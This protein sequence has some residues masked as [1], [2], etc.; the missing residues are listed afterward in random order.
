[1]RF[2]SIIGNYY[3][4][5]EELMTGQQHENKTAR[6]FPYRL[7]A[8]A[9][10]VVVA[11]VCGPMA[12]LAATTTLA[13]SGG[14]DTRR[15]QAACNAGRVVLADGVF[16]VTAV[17]CRNIVS[18]NA[19]AFFYYQGQQPTTKLKGTSSSVRGVLVCPSPGPCLYRGFEVDPPP[20][21]GGIVLDGIHGAQLLEMSVIDDGGGNSGDCVDMNPTTQEDNQNIFVRGGT[22]E[23]CG[24]WCFDFG[25]NSSGLGLSDSAWSGVDVAD[26]QAGGI[27]VSFGYNNHFTDNRIQDQYGKVGIRLDSGGVDVVT[28][29]T[30]D[31][32][33]SD[34]VLGNVYL[35]ATGNMS[36]RL[37]GGAM[38]DI[39]GQVSINA[40][41]NRSCNPTYLM[42]SNG[43]F[44][45]G[46]FYDP[47]PSYADQRTQNLLSGAIR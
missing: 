34:I 13:P 46:A 21:V 40:S 31:Q 4:R 3:S 2:D 33:Y 8:I 47:L 27:Y 18:E 22:Y 16:N 41:A 11:F 6:V 17:T 7:A 25:P 19:D 5:R 26:C 14:D 29:N 43:Q 1:V 39:E 10:I 20:G 23:H 38:F 30:F 12:G 24:G 35:V 45:G 37:Q 9:A 32:N 15:I 36:C 44:T 42:G 28:G